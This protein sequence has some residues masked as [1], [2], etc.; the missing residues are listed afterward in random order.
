MTYPGRLGVWSSLDA[1]RAEEA[2]MFADQV[3]D[4]GYGALWVPE[5]V[6][7][8]PFALLG[9]LAAHTTRLVL[10]TGIASIWARTAHAARAAA[11]ALAE[12]SGGRFILGLGAS[13]A[14]IVEGAHR[15]DYRRPLAAMSSYLDAYAAASYRGPAPA[16]PPPVVIA[17][18]RRRMLALSV[19]KADGAFPYLVPPEHVAAARTVVPKEKML[20]VTQPV[21]LT[22]DPSA[23]REA[24]RGYLSRYLDLPNC[25]Q[26][27]QEFG[28][29][30]DDLAKPGSDRLCDALVAWGSV[31]KARARI[32]EMH[33]AG[34]DH[35]AVIP[36]RADGSMPRD[37]VV[38]ALAP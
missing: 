37:E 33:D 19:D 28:F 16:E 1:L 30:D 6:G 27:L 14:H 4:L 7:R 22:D 26:N 29:E 35:V 34:A 3:E 15:A 32:D 25:R 13:H 10:G 12:L 8:E 2:A 24:A 5:S 17:A 9:Y 11:T 21:A 20:V 38:Q 36:L 18:L 23:A 31:E